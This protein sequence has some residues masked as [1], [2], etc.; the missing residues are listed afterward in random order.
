MLVTTPTMTATATGM[1]M[2]I[3]NPTAE[4]KQLSTLK[5]T[6]GCMESTRHLLSEETKL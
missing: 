6:T 2:A 3:I 1:R 4:K 5:I